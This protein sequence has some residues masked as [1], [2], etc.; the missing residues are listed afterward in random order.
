MLTACSRATRRHLQIAVQAARH[1]ARAA[2]GLSEESLSELPVVALVGRPNVGKSA[3]FN[4]LVKRKEALVQNTPEG[5][6]TR[7]YREGLAS[8]GDLHFKVLDTSGLEPF[9]EASSIQARATTLTL[10][11]LRRCDLA[12]LLL[13]ARSGVSVVDVEL[14]K[15]LRAAAP[16]HIVLAA[17]KAEACSRRAA[18]ADLQG[19]LSDAT[20]LGLGEAVAISAETGDGMVDL[21][22]RLQPL[23]DQATAAR[24]A[25]RASTE[26]AGAGAPLKIAI[27]GLPNVGKSSLSNRL[28][29][30]ERSLTGPEPGLTRDAVHERFVWQDHLIEL[31]DTA[32]WMRRTR[33]T[34]FDDSGGAIAEQALKEGE[35]SMHLAQV[36]LVVVDVL[37]ARNSKEIMTR[38][39]VSLA[40]AVIREGRA[41]LLV[42]NKLD[43][44][45]AH[46]REEAL[47]RLRH[48]VSSQLPELGGVRCVP[49]SARTGEGM[50]NIMPAVLQLYE[51]WNKRISTARLNTWL[52]KV[53]AFQHGTANEVC[54]VRYMTQLK[55]RPPTFVAFVRGS[56]GMADTSQKYLINALRKEFG[57][58]GIPLRLL[59]RYK[60]TLVQNRLQLTK[61]RRRQGNTGHLDALALHRTF[62]L[63]K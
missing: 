16:P 21:Y 26:E 31:V 63:S 14:A 44:L 32:G 20:R 45:P 36:V 6:V 47:G 37:H 1:F 50:D 34:Q 39:E 49:I 2:Q 57:L 46:Q 17:N 9:S 19:A 52:A 40:S 58:A 62:L 51:V 59:I 5:H 7:D 15:W 18:A 3:L 56:G 10:A 13:D 30:R 41:L 43:A 12:L 33:L 54:R 53:V 22:A 28:L 48:Q 24:A 61:A 35:R 29:A 11:V 25:R 60:K 38:R 55:P 42:L 4:R 8:L 27:M 23:V